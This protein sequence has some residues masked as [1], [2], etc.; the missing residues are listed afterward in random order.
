MAFRIAN[1]ARRDE[2]EG[3]LERL[4]RE[5]AERDF[6]LSEKEARFALWDRVSARHKS[7]SGYDMREIADEIRSW[8]KRENGKRR[9]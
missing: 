2:A 4:E 3:E 9:E 5:L 8:T 6:G 7:E 1:R